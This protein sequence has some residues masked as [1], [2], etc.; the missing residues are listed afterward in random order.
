MANNMKLILD[1]LRVFVA[2][3][4]MSLV[5]Y[6]SSVVRIYIHT[7]EWHYNL[8]EYYKHNIS[9]RSFIILFFVIFIAIILKRHKNTQ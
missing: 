3:V 2:L 7:H 5:I 6:F 1:L 4:L 9:I 8:L